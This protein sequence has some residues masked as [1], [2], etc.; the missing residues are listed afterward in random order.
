[1]PFPANTVLTNHTCHKVK[2]NSLQLKELPA[3]FGRKTLLQ[4]GDWLFKTIHTSFT[5]KKYIQEFSQPLT[6]WNPSNRQV[7]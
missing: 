1:M 3:L 6:S 2:D 4:C 7:D 5:E